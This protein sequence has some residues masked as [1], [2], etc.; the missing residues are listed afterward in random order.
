MHQLLVETLSLKAAA[1]LVD[2]SQGLL[3]RLLEGAPNRH[4]FAD[5]LHARTHCLVDCGELAKVPS[6]HLRN[7]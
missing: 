1:T 6:R 5:A 3:N 4:H 7:D 2:H